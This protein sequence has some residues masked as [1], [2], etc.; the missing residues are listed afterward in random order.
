[1]QGAKDLG[2][3]LLS[4]YNLAVDDFGKMPLGEMVGNVLTGAWKHPVEAFLDVATLGQL[5]GATKG[6]SSLSKARKAAQSRDA[7]VRIAEETT[8]E[9]IK[10]GSISQ[11]FVKEIDDITR[12]YDAD[13]IARGMQAVETIGFRNAPK[14]LLGVMNDLTKANDTYKMFT[15][16][17]GAEILDDVEFATR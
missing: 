2:D 8:K 7:L 9:N 14:E 12:K 6:I 17:A 13:T 5:T 3:A 15:K 4:T 11:D 10:L 16:M 1:M